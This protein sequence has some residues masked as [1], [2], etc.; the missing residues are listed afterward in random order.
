MKENIQ[1]C[2]SSPV[3]PKL[4]DKD[5]PKYAGD[6]ADKVLGD[7]HTL[8]SSDGMEEMCRVDNQIIHRDW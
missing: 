5:I 4:K 1:D 8:S 7:L 2:P 3:E 6:F